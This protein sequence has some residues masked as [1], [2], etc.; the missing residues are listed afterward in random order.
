MRNESETRAEL[1][2]PHLQQQ[3]WAVVPESRIRR[4]YPI[5]KGRLIGSGKRAMPDKAD[6]ILQFNNRNVAVLEAKAEGCYYTEGLAQAKD[7]ATRLNLRYA[8][9]TNGVKY[10][11]ADLQGKEGDI[12]E[13]PTPEQLWE[14]LYAVE[15]K[16]KPEAFNWEQ[17]F[18]NVP[19]ETKGGSWELRYYQQNAINKVLK[20]VA[21]D[22][23]KIL[24]TLAT[25]TGKTAVAFQIAWKLFQAKWNIN[26]DGIRSP[27]IL[28]LADRNILADQAF[29]AFG[30]FEE[31][32]LKRIKPS[33]I[34][35][36]GKVPTNGSIF[37]TIFQTFMSGEEPNFGQYPKDFFDFIIVDECHRGGANDESTWRAILEYFEPAT[38]LGLTATPKRDVNGDTYKYFGEPVSVYSL[39]EGINDGFL[40]PF[41][42]KQIQTNIDEYQFTS[43]DILV[44]GEVDAAREYT[45]SDFNRIITIK[46]REE[47]R[48]KEFLKMINQNQ[49]TLVFCATQ[50]HA[51]AVRDLIN[52]HCESKNPNYCQR[53]TA[54]DGV[55]GEKH[56]RDFQDNEKSI[57]TILTTSQKL[58]T[59]VDAP[60]IRNIILMRPVNSMIEFKQIVGR[61]TRLF[62]GKDY[63]TIYDFV[64][65]YKHFNDP[66][67]D[68]EPIEPEPKEPRIPLKECSVCSQKPCICPKPDKEPCEMCGY[69]ECRCENQKEIIEVVLSDGKVRQ[70][71]SMTTTTFWS[72]DG[73]PIT[74]TE[75]LK[76]LYGSIPDLFHSE[77]DLKTQWCVPSTRKSLL[78][79]LSEKGFTKEQLLEFQKI[80]KAENSDIYDVL[81]YVAYQSEILERE[82]RAAKM[83]EHFAALNANHQEFL[84]FVL[85][86]YIL[87]GVYELD[88]EKLGTFLQLKYKTI[89]DAKPILGDL[90]TI[91]NN[92]IEYQKYLYV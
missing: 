32:A 73:K 48:V 6:Y 27:R 15:K 8:I 4:E 23:K 51:L 28:F 90:K 11:M 12:T 42:V 63:F 61:G 1:I 19:F 37:F 5:T 78:E 82:Q 16:K 50:D 47:Y 56:L 76:T 24:I 29:N 69:I 59:G 36:K 86:Q 20:A 17:R 66:A 72:P 39:K 67:W 62:E 40:T 55:I 49:K 7:Y 60:E 34:S 83:R 85:N 65:A 71:Q 22:Q 84:E 77:E 21:N 43:D 91:R 44:S 81:S 89:A 80:L 9:C 30:A 92:F 14:N 68:G 88:D 10:Y 75:F 41:R 57:P 33:E 79:K 18:F 3:G 2:D 70:L 53:V 26:K 25:G 64:K 13:V 54:N 35:K 45:E 31:D 46:A 38:Q 87:N 52:Q 74:A 58:S